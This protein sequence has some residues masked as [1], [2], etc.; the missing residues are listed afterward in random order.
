MQLNRRNQM[1]N[2]RIKQFVNPDGTF[3]LIFES[4]DGNDKG[5]YVA[6][7]Y[8]S[9]G[10]ARSL[11]NV[12][13]KTR[14]KEGVDKSAPSF[15]RPMGD[16]AVDEGQKLRITTPIRGNPIPEFSWTKEG[17]PIDCDRANFFSDGELIGL[18]IVNANTGDSG[19][20]E[21]HITNEVGKSVGVCNAE[22]RKVYSAPLFSKQL[23]NVKQLLNCDAKFVCDVGA[24]PRPE[25]G[26]MFNG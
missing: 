18:E 11:A 13:I 4:T 17:K 5:A 14:L 20:Y 26:W 12:A 8:N 1:D 10:T 6:I 23:N 25:V 19:K 24:N 16:I 21:C 2:D 22:V 9:E 15:A 3:G 7:A